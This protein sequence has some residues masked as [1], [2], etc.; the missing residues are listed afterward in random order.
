MTTD[1]ARLTDSLTLAHDD[2]RCRAIAQLRALSD[3]SLDQQPDFQGNR[4]FAGRT[5]PSTRCISP[6]RPRRVR[7]KGSARRKK[8]F[9]DGSDVHGNCKL[10]R[11]RR[12][13]ESGVAAV[14]AIIRLWS[15]RRGV[16]FTLLMNGMQT[17]VTGMAFRTNRGRINVGMLLMSVIMF[18][19]MTGV[20]RRPSANAVPCTQ[21]K[22]EH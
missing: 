10:K 22:R 11:D 15:A 20:W 12:L 2:V 1:F 14:L 21:Q 4:R 16:A 8:R 17:A 5:A 3:R 6:N 18:G 13:I 9:V 19:A 7:E